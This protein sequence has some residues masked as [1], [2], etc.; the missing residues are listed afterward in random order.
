MISTKRAAKIL[1]EPDD[2]KR[3]VMIDNL[4]GD[5]AKYLLKQCISTVRKESNITFEC[6]PD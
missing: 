6:C 5:D 2:D 4:S 1:F 3:N